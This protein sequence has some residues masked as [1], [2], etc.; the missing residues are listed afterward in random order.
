MLEWDMWTGHCGYCTGSLNV[1]KSKNANTHRGKL[2]NG[3]LSE[4]CSALSFS[5]A[6]R[7][8]LFSLLYIHHHSHQI[9]MSVFYV[10]VNL[11]SQFLLT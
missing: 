9:T 6:M 8:I 3:M 4:L 7:F 2:Q 1:L 5:K 11:F 10:L